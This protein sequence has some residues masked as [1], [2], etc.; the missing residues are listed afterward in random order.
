MAG[1]VD[2]STINIVV[3]IIIIIIIKLVGG[4]SQVWETVNVL[5]SISSVILI[6]I[7]IIKNNHAGICEKKSCS[8]WE[9]LSL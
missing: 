9:S 8:W 1:A 5:L 4:L 2:D 3:V 7:I 6:I